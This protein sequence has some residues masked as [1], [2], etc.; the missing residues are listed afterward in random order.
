MR[1]SMVAWLLVGTIACGKGEPVDSTPVGTADPTSGFGTL[2]LTFRMNDDYFGQ[3]DAE[4]IGT[5][6]GAFWH[7]A[8][9]TSLG[10]NDGAVDLGSIEVPNVDLRVAGGPTA[11]MFTS[12]PLPVEEIVVLGFLDVDG[13]GAA[14]HD[15]DDK[16][17]VTL[18]ND[19]DFDV[20]GDAETV[21]EVYFGL[22]NP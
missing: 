11:V 15:P 14:T 17:P 18:P 19:N 13:N 8:D 7:G 4:A 2:A 1:G 12:G 22:L 20:I 21:V 3:M 16:D 9:V 6:Y 10:P 5:F